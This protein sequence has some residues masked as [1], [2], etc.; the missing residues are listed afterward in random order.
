MLE[1]IFLQSKGH[2][3]DKK[4][5]KLTALRARFLSFN[6]KK[7][8]ASLGTLHFRRYRSSPLLTRI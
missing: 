1:E 2:V 3:S 5:K 7:L 8:S 6:A 4:T